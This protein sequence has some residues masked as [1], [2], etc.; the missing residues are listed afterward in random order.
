MAALDVIRLVKGDE[1]PVI[2]LTLTDDVTG[3]PIDL[4]STST[5]ASVRFRA[6]GTTTVLSTIVCSKIGTGA[7]GQIQFDFSGGVL[8]IDPGMYEGEVVLNFNGQVQT[9]FDTI[10]FTVRSSF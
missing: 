3:A 7:T 2:I 6:A 1:R 10:R 9:V 5:S 4:S 8:D